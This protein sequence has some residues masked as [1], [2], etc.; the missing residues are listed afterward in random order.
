M[1]TDRSPVSRQHSPRARRLILAMLVVQGFVLLACEP[2]LALPTANSPRW[3]CPSPTA[4]PT[5]IKASIPRP[6]TTPGVDHRT[7]DV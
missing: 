1:T 6:T 2:H 3:A 7:D 4:L 5:R